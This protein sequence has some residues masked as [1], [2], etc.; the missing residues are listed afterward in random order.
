M[1][2]ALLRRAL[3]EVGVPIAVR[4]WDGT[5]TAVGPRGDGG[6][7]VVFQDPTAFWRLVASPTALG[8]GEAYVAGHVDV[9]GDLFAAMRALHRLPDRSPRLGWLASRLRR[10]RPTTSPA[11]AIAHHYDLSNDFYALFLDR[12]MVYTCAYYRRPDADLD[13]AQTDKLDLVCRKLQLGPGERLLDLGC[14]WGALVMWAAERYGVEAY[15]VTLS[16][17]QA[18]WAR[19]EIRR[20][21]LADRARVEHLD[22]RGVEGTDRFEKIA[23][24][25]LI[26]HVGFAAYAD[27]FAQVRRLLAPGGLF[28]NHGITNHRDAPRTSESEFLTRHVFP[29]TEIPSVSHVMRSMEDAGFEIDHVENLRPHYARTTRAWAERLQARADEAR[30]LVGNRTHRTWLGYL[31]A[32][33]QAFEEG[34]IT[35]H[36]VVARPR[37]ERREATRPEAG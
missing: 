16:A 36:Q 1:A 28:L 17:A 9:E 32:A 4:L 26:E 21:G 33:S 24:I 2:V 25:G 11:E 3:T 6:F 22:Y 31:A 15:G 23:S 30:V 27:Y 35:L 37:G 29:G 10:R 20:R 13:E 8:F 12:R 19:D 18:S 34:W 5:T 14:G 7:T